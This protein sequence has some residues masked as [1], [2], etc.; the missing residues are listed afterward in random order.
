M[1]EC[2]TG[3]KGHL[4]EGCILA[5]FMGLG[6][7]LQTLTLIR[8][9]IITKVVKKIVVVCP[10]T[11]LKVWER[12][13]TKW[14]GNKLSPLV[15]L[16]SSDEITKIVKNFVDY[17]YRFLIISYENFYKHSEALSKK[18]DLL[19]FDEGHRLKNKKSKFIK[20]IQTFK[21]KKRILLTGTPLQNNLD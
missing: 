21:C 4:I 19:I 15:T 14:M 20:K 2:I 6:K 1:Y 11:L 18:S 7:T 9:A 3:K 5:D 10:L 16:G 8:C 17:D 12:E 13:C